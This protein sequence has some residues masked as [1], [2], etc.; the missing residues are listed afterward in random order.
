MHGIFLNL[1]I[2]HSGNTDTCLIWIYWLNAFIASAATKLT[3]TY[4][5]MVKKT[6]ILYLISLLFSLYIYTYIYTCNIFIYI[7]VCIYICIYIYIYIYIFIYIYICIYIYVYIYICIYYTYIYVYI[8]IYAKSTVDRFCLR[9]NNYKCSLRVALEGANPKQ[10]YFHQYFLSEDH[11]G[12][13]EDCEITLIDKND[14]WDPTRRELFWMYELKTFY[15]AGTEY[16]GPCLR[17][18]Y[19][20][21]VFQWSRLGVYWRISTSVL[22]DNYIKTKMGAS[23]SAQC[24]Q[25]PWGLFSAKFKGHC[26]RTLQRK[27]PAKM[28]RRHSAHCNCHRIC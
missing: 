2:S 14:S 27:N 8:F 4:V 1:G 9:W 13:L 25:A 3:N 23:Q 24:L 18:I 15:A 28:L 21:F 7:Y 22:I 20:A 12:L 19:L 5:C 16:L 11:Y 26:L 6:H 10:N 17:G